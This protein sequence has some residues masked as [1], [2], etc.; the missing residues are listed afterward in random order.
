MGTTF[1][2]GLLFAAAI[3]SGFGYSAVAGAEPTD[4]HPAPSRE[5]DIG[6]YDECMAIGTL[7][8]YKCCMYSDGEWD[9]EN[10]KCVAPAP[11]DAGEPEQTGTPPVLQNPPQQTGPAHPLVPTPRGSHSGT[12]G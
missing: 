5:W 1:S 9:A 4:P 10:Y 7:S 2:T 12:L 6:V 3:V 11:L 8:A